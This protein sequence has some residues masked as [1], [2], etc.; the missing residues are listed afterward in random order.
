MLLDMSQT[1]EFWISIFLIKKKY[2]LYFWLC[3]ASL[4]CRIF[5]SCGKQ[6]LLS[7]YSTQASHCKGFSCCRARA[8]GHIRVI[9]CS[10]WAQQLWLPDSRAQAQQL[11][12]TGLLCCKWDIPGS[13]I[14]LRPPAIAGIFFTCEP[15][16]RPQSSHFEGH[17][18]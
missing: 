3:C 1:T 15:S 16:E 12:L 5:S 4:L 6:G 17:H 18:Y 11:H 13:G 10:T 8:L 2:L 9:S 14:K 7:S